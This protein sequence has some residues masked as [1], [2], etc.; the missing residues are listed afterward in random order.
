MLEFSV[1]TSVLCNYRKDL[2]RSIVYKS[3]RHV[4]IVIYVHQ[5][6]LQARDQREL[7]RLALTVRV[8]VLCGSAHKAATLR[9]QLLVESGVIWGKLL[10]FWLVHTGALLYLSPTTCVPPVF[11]IF[12]SPDLKRSLT[13]SQTTTGENEVRPKWVSRPGPHSCN[14]RHACTLRKGT[15][16]VVMHW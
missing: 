14:T 7:E 5:T 10:S 16:C 3:M 15:H 6:L 11:S 1:R 8:Q 2:R 12:C 9:R 13:F 4:R